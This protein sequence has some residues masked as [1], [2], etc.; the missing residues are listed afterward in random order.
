M[1]LRPNQAL[2]AVNL[3][4]LAVLAYMTFAPEAGASAQPGNTRA[5]GDYTM[6]AGEV[7]FGNSSAVWIVDSANQEIVAIR[8][9]EGRRNFEG[10][11]YRNLGDDVNAQPGR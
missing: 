3:A 7:N 10:I 5:R 6:V 2:I 9:D 11:G 8:W 1:R 4:L